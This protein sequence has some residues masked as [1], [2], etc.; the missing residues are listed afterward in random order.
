MDTKVAPQSNSTQRGLR[1]LPIIGPILGLV[2]TAF[3]VAVA[4]GLGSDAPGQEFILTILPAYAPALV[5]AILI[6]NPG[7]EHP[8]RQAL[9]A[10]A[11]VAFGLVAITVLV[12]F[13]FPEATGLMIAG[14]VLSAVPFFA[15]GV[16]AN[17]RR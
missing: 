1:F 11:P 7:R 9:M 14:A 4:M 5:L 17:R 6:G 3:L 15:A 12:R 8:R 16:L 2:T 10:M 13:P